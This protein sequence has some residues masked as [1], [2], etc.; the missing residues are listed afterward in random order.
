MSIIDRRGISVGAIDP[1]DF[2]APNAGVAVKTPCR[3]ATAGD[4]VLSGLLTVDGVVLADGDRVLVWRQANPVGNG[5]WTASTGPWS[6]ASDFICYGQVRKGTR[7]FVTDGDSYTGREFFV[8]NEGFVDIGVD[9]ISFELGE[10]L[11]DDAAQAV[12]GPASA[13]IG[14]IPV[15]S[16]TDGKHL[17][18]SGIP[19]SGLAIGA[20]F[21]DTKALAIAAT[22]GASIHWVRLAGYF[23][24]GD[25]GEALYKKVGSAPTH[26]GKFQST[27]GAWWEIV[28]EII[29]V[30]MVGAIPD[31]ATQYVANQTAIQGALAIGR[32]VTLPEGHT[33]YTQAIVAPT[34]SH[35][36]FGR[37]ALAGAGSYSSPNAVLYIANTTDF[38]V[39]DISVAVDL[40]TLTTTLGVD[41]STNTNLTIQ[42]VKTKGFYGIRDAGSTG[43]RVLDCTVPDH[44]FIGILLD[45]SS[46]VSVRGCRVTSTFTTTQH[47]G[48]QVRASD[49]VDVTDNY[50][51]KAY[52][53]GIVVSGN[54]SSPFAPTTGIT[55]NDNRVLNS[56]L[57]AINLTNARGFAVV[58]NVCRW[59]DGSSRD[60]GISVYA[61]PT[62]TPAPNS[63]IGLIA[64]NT[65][66]QSGKC[67]ISLGGNAQDITVAANT[68]YGANT[69]NGST[70][71]YTAGIFLSGTGL[72][73]N[74]V[75]GN[76][77]IDPLGHLH[78]AVNELNDHIGSGAGPDFNSFS[79]NSGVGS[80]GQSNVVG[81]N[82]SI[83]SPE[84]Y[85][86]GAF[87]TNGNWPLG[88][89][90]GNP[91]V[92]AITPFIDF[93]SSGGGFDFDARI[94][95]D[96]GG[97][98]FGKARLQIA[99]DVVWLN[100]P[101]GTDFAGSTS[102]NTRLKAAAIASGT[103]TLP[104]A[105]DTLMANA[106]A[107][108]MTNKTFDTAGTG[109]VF[110]INGT[111]IT[112]KTGSGKAVLD[113][114]PTL[115]GT[116]L[117]P[118][119]ANGTNTTQIATT[120]F[121]LATRLDQ[122]AAPTADVSLNSHKLT[123]LTDPSSAQDA[124]TKNYVDTVAQGLD[125]K[126]SVRA[127]TTANGTL[128]TAFANGQTIDGVVLAT[129]NRILLKNQTTQADN[130]IYVVNASGAPTRAADFDNWSEVP[131]AF[132][133]VEEGTVNGNTGWTCTSDAGGTIGS[134]AVVFTQFSGAGSYTAGA[135]L[136]LTGT[137]F[138]IDSTVATLA[139]AQALSNKTLVTPD[140]GVAMGTS[141]TLTSST[142]FTATGVNA[143]FELGA[144]A[145]PNT[146]FIDFNSS[147]NSNDYDVRLIASGGGAGSGLGTMTIGADVINLGA[148][149]L[150]AMSTGFSNP[151]PV[152]KTGTSGSQGQTDASLIINASG[153]FTLTLLSAATYP[154]RW[155]HIKS[156]AAQT[157]N[158]ASANIVPIGSAAAAAALLAS[159]AGKWAILQSN[160]TNWVVM[161]SN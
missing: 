23:A 90:L 53:F 98:T 122:L 15:F 20:Q 112:D 55:I 78:W 21:Y 140:I 26:I 17:E 114:S 24:A 68:I 29:S 113:T 87:S 47:Y 160:G 49:H 129:G 38:L 80:L 157:I 123:N 118:T 62:L 161:A 45:A 51:E 41:G 35:S 8:V 61:D 86:R 67:G 71:D 75:T 63:R 10:R 136:Q 104:A 16:N 138:S 1:E 79:N 119:P 74:K 31:D 28:D 77:I 39:R 66:Y 83:G 4:Q 42:G 6:R 127:A 5:I 132:A 82:S 152:T 89:E 107:A 27:D 106:F 158:S 7:V 117:A 30:L 33:F 91:T 93:H 142:P 65:I 81:A 121:V 141:L 9:E 52:Q 156:I 73:N 147:G 134:T 36:L 130:G 70:D 116:P 50:V 72:L 120:A 99:A 40:A 95:A 124:A 13:G 54:E 102:G 25:G 64:G 69:L 149:N 43:T 11:I 108:V 103:L 96:G 144:K 19:A 59:T 145:T 58:G 150:I 56:G 60:F 85:S 3:V 115:A 14:N 92:A 44:N 135:G 101:S 105:T 155:L 48:I 131:G 34:N 37:G 137:Q 18:D 139:G 126:Q 148:G 46:Q 76:N 159:G 143:N 111:Q 32:A 109:N 97:G 57:E 151:V 84:F 133:F 88:F 2:P 146:P 12:V 110:K 125:A 154:G 128:A 100:A 153:A 94:I 22:I